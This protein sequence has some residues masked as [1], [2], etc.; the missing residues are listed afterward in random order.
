MKL[1]EFIKSR[2]ELLKRA[3]IDAES[4]KQAGAM[5]PAGGPPPMD[6]SM[7]GGGA[8]PPMDPAMMGGAPMDPAAMGGAMTPPPAGDPNQ[9]GGADG[10]PSMDDLLSMIEEFSD[11]MKQQEQELNGLKN[12]MQEMKI[13]F[14]EAM[15][16]VNNVLDILNKGSVQAPKVPT[17]L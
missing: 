12:E 4:L 13:K 11:G 17:G 9:G 15:T 7:V 3:F 8:M 6:P 16:T 14:A 1:C 10:G 2:P 5:P